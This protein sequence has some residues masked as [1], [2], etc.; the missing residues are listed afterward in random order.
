MMNPVAM[1]FFLAAAI[2][3][4][5]GCST[6]IEPRPSL[7]DMYTQ[8][9]KTRAA[10]DAVCRRFASNLDQIAQYRD[11]GYPARIAAEKLVEQ[12]SRFPIDQMV[13]EVY[14]MSSN[15]RNLETAAA[16]IECRDYGYHTTVRVLREAAERRSHQK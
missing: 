4:L 1:I 5:S 6:Q 13:E 10:N 11:D 14:A 9:V 16:F 2:Y 15:D 8:T 7:N 12:R 3:T